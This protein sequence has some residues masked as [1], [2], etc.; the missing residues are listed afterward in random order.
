[1]SVVTTQIDIDAPPEEVWALVTDPQRTAEWVT[2]HRALK[3]H[4]DGEPRVGY[5][6]KQTLCLRGAKFDVNWEVAEVDAPRH[7]KWEGRGPARSHASTE[8]RLTPHNG[9][10]ALRLPQRVQGAARAARRDGEPRARRRASRR[11]RPTPP[12]AS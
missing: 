12:S 1:M 8:Y 7:L 5:E 2:I 11:R 10:H 3:S 9:G 6:M 4:S